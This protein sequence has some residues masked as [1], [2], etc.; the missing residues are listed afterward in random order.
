[1]KV[2]KCPTCGSELTKEHYQR[3]L[4]IVEEQRKAIRLERDQLEKERRL[5]KTRVAEAKALAERKA[6]ERTQR[7]V[8][9]KDKMID[10]LRNTVRQLRQ[11]T[12]PQSEGLE[13]E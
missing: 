6:L 2:Y 1:M 9:G 7:M 11:G 5:L 3:A 8:L 4:G 10:A 13:F 12:T